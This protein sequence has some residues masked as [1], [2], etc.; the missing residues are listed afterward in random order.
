MALSLSSASL[1][2]DEDKEDA[3]KC[4]EMSILYTAQQYV[5]IMPQTDKLA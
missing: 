1:L 3:E 2:L 5:M 4:S